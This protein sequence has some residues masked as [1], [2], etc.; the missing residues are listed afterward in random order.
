MCLAA[1][2]HSILRYLV[3][4]IPGTDPERRLRLHRAHATRCPS[5]FVALYKGPPRH[6]HARVNRKSCSERQKREFVEAVT[7]DRNS[8]YDSPVSHARY[9]THVCVLC[10]RSRAPR[11]TSAAS[12]PFGILHA[13]N[14]VY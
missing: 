14:G 9:H 3:L 12:T 4:I 8:H 10:T 1:V 7:F 11:S 6:R 13:K 5:A 2:S